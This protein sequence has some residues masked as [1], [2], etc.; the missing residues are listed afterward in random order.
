MSTS[1]LQR[2]F[3]AAFGMTVFEFIRNEKLNEA[4]RLLMQEGISVGEAAYRAGYSSA[5]NFT[6][7][8]KRRFGVLPKHLRG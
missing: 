8:F 6:T 7:A 2:H 3:R 5:A 1:S 4:W